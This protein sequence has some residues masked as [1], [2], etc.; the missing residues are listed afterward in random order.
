[1]ASSIS[2]EKPAHSLIGDSLFVMICFLLSAFKILLSFFLFTIYS[3][4]LETEHVVG[5]SGG[6]RRNSQADSAPSV[7]SDSGL[8]LMTQIMTQAKT[9][10]QM[11]N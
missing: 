8:S 9:K 11:L 5:R 4:I 7:E 10:S 3:F 1:M 6:R 2:S